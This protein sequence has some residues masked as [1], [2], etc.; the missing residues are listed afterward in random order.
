MEAQR[1]ELEVHV[2]LARKHRPTSADVPQVADYNIA[3]CRETEHRDLDPETV[4]AGVARFIGEPG[5]GRYFVAERDGEV[6]GQTALTY[7][8]SDWRNGEFWWIQSVY[9]H[10]DHRGS[11]VFRALF[12]HIR[13][14][15]DAD[16]DC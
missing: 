3:L 15:G 12:G 4:L 2:L 7:E 16:V 6:V 10:P 9:V 1:P 8:W 13:E 14:L 5:N 11:G